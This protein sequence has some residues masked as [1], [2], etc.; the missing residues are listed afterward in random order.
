MDADGALSVDGISYVDDLDRE[1]RVLKVKGG[2]GI[3]FIAD[4]SVPFHPPL[5][6]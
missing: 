3:D 6:H 5:T 2:H 4:V 1:K